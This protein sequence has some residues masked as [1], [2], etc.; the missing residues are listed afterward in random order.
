[1]SFFSSILQKLMALAKQPFRLY[2]ALIIKFSIYTWEIWEKIGV[3]ITPDRFNSPIPNT[4]TLKEYNWGGMFPLDGIVLDDDLML[5]LLKK[6]QS[7]KNEYYDRGSSYESNGEGNI[8][9]GLIREFKPEMIIE[10]GGGYSTAVSMDALRKNTQEIGQRSKILTI[11]PYPTSFLERL[12]AK[13]EN[14]VTLIRKKVEK[15][16]I[17]TFMQL[18]AGEI[19]FIDS[20]HVVKCGN[21]VHFLYLHLL[22]KINVGTIIHI[23]DILFP[24]D[25]P[26]KWLM[27]KKYFWNEQY[28][29]HIF[30]CFNDSY[31]IL[32]A[33]NYLRK[34]YPK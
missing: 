31:K 29:L 7:T 24:C 6:I 8:L 22:P 13:E 25:Y 30:L 19:L 3:H 34:K 16:G 10:V 27:E 18:K 32:F 21:D 5:S 14:M 17:E 4:K 12:V 28:L 11:E 33:S 9:Y 1:M 23:H 20:S 26:K 2:P 15:V